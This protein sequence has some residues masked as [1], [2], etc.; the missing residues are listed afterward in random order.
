MLTV[1][2]NKTEQLV[3]EHSLH[4]FDLENFKR[5]FSV[6][7]NY[8]PLMYN[9]YPVSPEDVGFVL[10]YLDEEIVFDFDENAYFIECNS[11]E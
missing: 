10:K 7:D 3:A 2:D 9:V 5:Q 1:F 4:S 11:I 6:A 8:D